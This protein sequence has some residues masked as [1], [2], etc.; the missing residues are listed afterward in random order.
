M[1]SGR[2][3]EG[4]PLKG[5]LG[6]F[7][8]VSLV[9]LYANLPA[10]GQTVGSIEGMVSDNTGAILPGVTVEVT[11]DETGI[12][13]TVVTDDQGRYRARELGLGQYSVQASLEGFRTVVR[14]GIILTLGRE[15]VIDLELPIGEL[16][17]DV[18]V[19]A[20]APLVQTRSGEVT[21]LV[22][23]DQME[24]LPLNTRDFSQLINLQAGTVF[25][26]S[27]QGNRMSGYGSRISVSGARPTSN[28][29][30]LDGSEIQTAHGQMPS[31]VTGAQL[32]LEAVQEFRVLTSNY[33]AQYGRSAGAT[34]VAATR[35]GTNNL[36]GTA[37]VYH[38]ND[39]LDAKNFFD[40][41]KPEFKRNQ[42]GVSL[43]GPILKNKTFFFGNFEGL[44]QRLPERMF[45]RV[46]TAAA[47][48]GILPTATVP[49]SAAVQPYLALFPQ[50]TGRDYGDGTAEYFRSATT[51][52]DQKYVTVRVDHQVGS[53]NSLFGRYTIDESEAVDPQLFGFYEDGRHTRMQF[54]TFE[55]KSV[56]SAHLVHQ[57]RISY[58]RSNLNNER[59]P[60]DAP[61][62]A[63]AV[64]PGRPFPNIAV[65]GLST[66]GIGESARR[67]LILSPQLHSDSSYDRGRHSLRFGGNVTLFTIPKLQ[68][69]R[70][71]GD[72]TWGSLRDFLQNNAPTRLRIMGFNAD[73]ERTFEQQMFAAY[74]QDDIQA[75]RN[76]TLNVG[77]RVEYLSTP[78]EK[79]GKLANVRNLTDA[80][81]T[82]GEPYYE[83]P[84]VFAAPR[85]GLAWDPTGDGKMSVRTGIGIFHE[86]L[87][88]RYYLNAM[89][90]MPPFWSDVDPLRS[91]LGGLFPDL[92]PYL[93]RLS[94]GPQ[95][96][97][98]FEFRPDNPYTMQWNLTLQQMLG[99]HL[100]AEVGYVGSRGVHLAGRKAFAVPVPTF[101]DGVTYY[102][103]NAGLYTPNFSRL[104]YYDT[105]ASSRY[106]SLRLTLSRRQA[107]GFHF[108][109]GYTWSKSMDTQSATLS[110]ELGA[111]TVMDPFDPMQDWGLSDFHVSHALN[112]NAG[113]ELPW[114]K[115][116][117]GLAGGFVRGWQVTGLLSM[118]TGTPFT[119]LSNASLTHAN[120]RGSYVRP[121]LVPGGNSNPILGGPEQY[122]D[123]TQFQVQ[124]PGFYGNVG[125]NTL[126]GPGLINLD[127]SLIKRQSVGRGNV[128]FR[129]E[130]FNILNR[131]NFG[132]PAA[133]LFNS[134]GQRIA[135]GRITSTVTTAR[136]IQL[137]LRFEF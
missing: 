71:G 103:P 45:G 112:A 37:Y 8:L 43:G 1:L 17:E 21:A 73:P 40:D 115:D 80:A 51:P 67:D 18:V 107:A 119:V 32:G 33:S 133:T 60:L 31:G 131:A 88:V 130:V 49:V 70:E 34:I 92:S 20:D 108:Q 121:D 54:L 114:G 106:H 63:L 12:A 136:Q 56:I 135:A 95:A 101:I 91:T 87:L 110:G 58:T 134:R 35:S 82:V 77:V 111:S 125:R 89:D 66:L 123:P 78:T 129:V 124:Q 22:S 30:T 127:A 69:S 102:P 59:N 55:L 5:Q 3:A 98:V 50:P 75:R 94:E 117:Q 6:F 97:H 105:S 113:Y 81:P 137:A 10:F 93:Q 11:N 100:V 96:V 2:N 44:R 74:V 79:D 104:E 14:R 64:Y 19:T 122:F 61:S 16:T 28:A 90:R 39:S 7:I 120:E 109:A 85:L 99:E 42:F 29:F 47:R 128:Q 116:L 118:H 9:L 53:A 65:T 24:D 26:R 41:E 23:R 48:Q 57:L 68:Y 84:G 83:N 13:R 25:Y 76:V 86:P 52:T 46:P 72:W 126:I 36:R 38:R 27:Q 15:A 62:D 4:S 132:L